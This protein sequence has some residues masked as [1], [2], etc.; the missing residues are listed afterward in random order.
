MTPTD[1]GR[2]F[3]DYAMLVTSELERAVAELEALNGKGHGV[4]RVGAGTMLMK[5]LL[6]QAV[7]R[8]M[9]QEEGSSVNFR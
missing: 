7:R 5:Y 1:Y 3:L 2:V 8:F 9:A 4:V 6:P